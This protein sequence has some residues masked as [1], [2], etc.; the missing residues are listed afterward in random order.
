MRF[1]TIAASAIIYILS[2]SSLNAQEPLSPGPYQIWQDVEG[3]KIC[4]MILDEEVSIGGQALTTVQSCL[5]TIDFGGDP[6][7]W[8]IDDEGWLRFT[9]AQRK[10]ILRFEPHEDGS[11]Y[12]RRTELQKENLVFSR[13]D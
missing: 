7:A 3:G 12:A 8:H 13:A 9:D 5:N 11:Y 4:D 1:T 10:L 6:I 2:T